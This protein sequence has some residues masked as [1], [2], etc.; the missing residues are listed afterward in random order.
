[1]EHPR[2]NDLDPD[3]PARYAFGADVTGYP[4]PDDPSLS[5]R[6]MDPIPPLGPPEAPVFGVLGSN[7]GRDTRLDL[8]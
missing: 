5:G 8:G 7:G 6:V 4:H 3:P 1:M 2:L